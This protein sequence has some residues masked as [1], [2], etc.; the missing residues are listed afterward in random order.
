M[1]EPSRQEKQRAQ[2]RAENALAVR[3]GRLAQQLADHPAW[4]EIVIEYLA[5]EQEAARA[6]KQFRPGLTMT[7]DQ[8]AITGA[9]YTGAD[10]QIQRL[11]VKID[12]LIS[13]GREAAERLK[14]EESK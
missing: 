5:S 9:Y 2:D 12:R 11:I 13:D 1:A 7:L 10:D 3:R 14:S 4:K 8:I 6:A